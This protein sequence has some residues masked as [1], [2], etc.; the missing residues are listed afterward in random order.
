MA[1]PQILNSWDDLDLDEFF[2]MGGA[3]G[4]LFVIEILVRR[5][6]VNSC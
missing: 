4:P 6:S 2:M 1:G 5:L 3:G